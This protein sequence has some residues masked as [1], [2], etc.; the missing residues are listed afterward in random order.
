MEIAWQ[1][2]RASYESLRQCARRGAFASQ[3][4]TSKTRA[5]RS[6]GIYISQ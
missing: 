1:A 3:S 4:P 6:V 5:K 2:R